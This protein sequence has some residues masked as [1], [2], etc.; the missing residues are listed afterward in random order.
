MYKE[1]LI[2]IMIDI[3]CLGLAPGCKILEIGACTFDGKYTFSQLI[4]RKAQLL[5]E[6][7]GTLDWWNKQEGWNRVSSGTLPIASVLA[8]FTSWLKKIELETG[9]KI[10][11]W[12][13][14]ASFDISILEHAYKAYFFY[15]IPWKYWN[16]MCFRTL[17]NLYGKE[18]PE[19]KFNGNKH[20]ALADAAHQ[21][22]WANMIAIYI[23]KA[24][25]CYSSMDGV[26][27]PESSEMNRA[28]DG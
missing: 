17:K 2:D 18:V 23:T 27:I 16:V 28:Y 25:F 26:S 4:E 10:R 19:P 12:G 5:S 6:D 14:A 24:N 11:V 15:D 13:N 20:E 3:E 7:K 8:L 22:Y 1:G 9:K 21:A